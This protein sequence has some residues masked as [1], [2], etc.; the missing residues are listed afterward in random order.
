MT[1]RQLTGPPRGDAGQRAFRRA[2]GC[3]PTGVT[4]VTTHTAEGP[5]GTTVGSFVSLSLDP[6]LVLLSLGRGSRLR[7]ALA[8]GHPFVVN[9]LAVDQEHAAR[10]FSGAHRPPGEPGFAGIAGYPAPA[11]GG[12]AL[13]GARAVFECRVTELHPAGDHDLVLGEVLWFDHDDA[14][15]PLVFVDSGYRT[16]GGARPPSTAAPTKEH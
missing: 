6:L 4:V 1:V 13:T 5:W 12:R 7:A 16:T 2:A 10:H 15:D 9:V 14:K 8:P 3:F 11:T